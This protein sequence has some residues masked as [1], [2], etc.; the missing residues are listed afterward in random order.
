MDVLTNPIMWK[1]IAH[2]CILHNK[3]IKCL[4]FVWTAAAYSQKSLSTYLQEW[5][6]HHV[7]YLQQTS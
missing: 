6:L 2:A 4:V 1:I 7:I 5:N 3:R